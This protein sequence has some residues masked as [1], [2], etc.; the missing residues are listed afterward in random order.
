MFY[1]ACHDCGRRRMLIRGLCDVC[2]PGLHE[3]HR[4][5]LAEMEI[6]HLEYQYDTGREPLSD[7]YAFEDWRRTRGM[8]NG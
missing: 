7:W 2:E 5:R 6:V 4:R 8:V 3:Q 1:F